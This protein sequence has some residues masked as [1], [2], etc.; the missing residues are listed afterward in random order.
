MPAQAPGSSL[1]FLYVYKTETSL[2]F[3]SSPS[4]DS[5]SHEECA[6]L[7]METASYSKVKPL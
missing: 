2:L 7:N 5:I 6:R 1:L 3:E 4:K